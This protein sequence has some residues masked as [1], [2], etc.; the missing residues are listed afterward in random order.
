MNKINIDF[1]SPHVIICS[2]SRLIELALLVLVRIGVLRVVISLATLLA[3]NRLL[4]MPIATVLAI[5]TG[6][7]LRAISIIMRQVFLLVI[8]HEA[9]M[10][11][12]WG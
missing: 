4:G 3:S 9:V 8:V 7:R 2:S 12:Y 6:P 5:L 10:M 11:L 1:I